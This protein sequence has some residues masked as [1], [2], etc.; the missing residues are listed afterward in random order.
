VPTYISIKEKPGIST[1][2]LSVEMK[3]LK[4]HRI[5]VDE[6]YRIIFITSVSII[7]INEPHYS[8]ATVDILDSH[9]CEPWN[10]IILSD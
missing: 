9:K 1:E 6:F 5:F 2:R 3:P 10:M 4:E 7:I 8:G